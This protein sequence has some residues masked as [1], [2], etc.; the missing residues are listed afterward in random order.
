[1]F[2]KFSVTRV[3][4]LKGL[5]D[6]GQNTIQIAINAYFINPGIVERSTSQIE[7]E[8]NVITAVVI[9]NHTAG[10]AA[11]PI[12][13]LEEFFDICFGDGVPTLFI[14]ITPRL[15]NSHLH[16][17]T[18]ASLNRLPIRGCLSL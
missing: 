18:Q 3:E 17:D 11:N 4:P 7:L 2:G 14:R 15:I 8:T 1:M 12:F 16:V 13:S 9:V 10:V 5:L 6:V